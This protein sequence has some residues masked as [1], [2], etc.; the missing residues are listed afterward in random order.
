VLNF[1]ASFK[2]YMPLRYFA[3]ACDLRLRSI[4]SCN[5]TGP[6]PSGRQPTNGNLPAQPRNGLHASPNGSFSD[7][8]PRLPLTIS[9]PFSRPHVVDTVETNNNV[10]AAAAAATTTTTTTIETLDASSFSDILFS[11][12]GHRALV[13]FDPE[14]GLIVRYTNRRGCLA[15]CAER[16]AFRVEE[17]LSAEILPPRNDKF[18]W[19][20]FKQRTFRMAIYTFRRAYD[21]PSH[22]YPRRIVL[23]TPTVG[24]VE[25]WA[26]AMSQAIRLAGPRRP[27]RLLVLVNPFGGKRQAMKLY[28]HVV[29]PVFHRAAIDVDVRETQFGGHARALLLDMPAVELKSFDGVV[30]VGGDGLFHEIVNAL[31]QL[32]TQASTTAASTNTGT[33]RNSSINGM[34]MQEDHH[35]CEIEEERSDYVGG[36]H[37]RRALF[38][39]DALSDAHIHNASTSTSNNEADARAN[40]Y[41]SR[42][43]STHAPTSSGAEVLARAAA[44]INLRVGHIPA[45]STDAVACTL[46][47]TRSA[48]SAAMRIALGDGIPLDVVRIDARDGSSRFAVSMASYGFMGDLMEESEGYR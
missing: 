7:R 1:L 34:M 31:L 24:L 9:A 38:P 27:R 15:T 6:P 16:E 5:V 2:I 4:C 37:P 26:A 42:H 17:I 45:G 28:S 19:K 25:L 33:T 36:E 21:S 11:V 18:L 41:A 13:T 3:S 12:D 39:Q 8:N 43:S 10:E 29:G 32:R 22:W 40:N 20:A 44:A 47:G 48:F 46:N 14:N 35:R 23:S 30:A